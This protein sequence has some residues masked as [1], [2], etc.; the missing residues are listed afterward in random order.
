MVLSVEDISVVNG[1]IVVGI[2]VGQ[3]VYFR[4]H[5][6]FIHLVVLVE[7]WKIQTGSW[8]IL[9]P[10]FYSKFMFGRV[11][12]CGDGGFGRGVGAVGGGGCTW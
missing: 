3:F 1:R 11:G 7:E 5:F 12:G 2:D 4:T 8:V 10:F 6:H 9:V